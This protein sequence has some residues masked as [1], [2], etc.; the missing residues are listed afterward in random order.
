M[1]IPDL[2]T[3]VALGLAIST[4]PVLAEGFSRI[5]KMILLDESFCMKRCLSCAPHLPPYLKQKNAKPDETIRRTQI[6]LDF[7]G[8][9]GGAPD[10][11]MGMR[12]R[13]AIRQFKSFMGF[14]PTGDLDDHQQA[15]LLQSYDRARYGDVAEFEQVVRT[16][17]TRGLLRFLNPTENVFNPAL[18]GQHHLPPVIPTVPPAP[19]EPSM[20]RICTSVGLRVQPASRAANPAPINDPAQALDEQFCAAR[21]YSIVRA[22]K[23]LD[24]ASSTS[25]NMA[26][27][28]CAQLVTTMQPLLDT[29]QT[30][31]PDDQIA[32]DEAFARRFADPRQQLLKVGEACLGVGYRDDDAPIVLAAAMLLLGVGETAYAEIF[33]HHLR[34]GLGI[35]QD[36]ARALDWYDTML[37][38]L[39]NGARPALLPRLNSKRKSII[40]AALS[41]QSA[42]NPPVNGTTHVHRR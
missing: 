42:A 23:L 25:K 5:G 19:A 31:A 36:A 28:K 29:L 18:I 34:L 24:H 32:A 38:A 27:E 41:A 30:S 20:A 21:D 3:G 13:I 16:E 7:F 6:A 22:V 39:D 14:A 11:F 15:V 4:Q 10:G 26:R 37:D 33:A 17:G 35:P 2:I 9:D 40:R 12:T 1:K 8:F